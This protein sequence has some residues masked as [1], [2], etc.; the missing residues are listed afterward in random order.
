M[1]QKEINKIDKRIK[2]LEE[3]IPLWLKAKGLGKK[4]AINAFS[5]I[6]ELQL[7]KEDLIN[8]THKYEIYKIKIEINQLNALKENANIIKKIQ[9]NYN[10]KKNYKKLQLLQK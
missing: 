7:K 8:G 9:Y 4:M 5:E 10:I 3:H 6:K 1:N 2:D